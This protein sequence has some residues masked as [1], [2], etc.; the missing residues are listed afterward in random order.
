MPHYEMKT[1]EG[2]NWVEV[3]LNNEM[4]RTES[5]AMRYMLGNIAMESKPSGGGGGGLL[6]GLIKAAVT[7]ESLFRP[8]Y[9]GTGK[10]VLEP[11]LTNFFA[12]QLNNEE[13]ILDR[14]AYWASDASIEV[15]AKRNEAISGLV[16]GEGLFQTSVRGTGT[17]IVQ[18]P[19]PVQTIDL[20]N[21]RLTV[22]GSFAVARTAG[23]NYRV[24]R[25][26]KS[27]LGSMTSGEG[28]VNVIEGT[29][30][31]YLAPVPN[32]YVMLQGMMATLAA[33]AGSRS[34]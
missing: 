26:T 31:V 28:I 10:L 17:V 19:G 21:N 7:G 34:G 29:G 20:Q 16:G 33:S 32:L 11:T 15:T 8:Q 22:D 5:G 2:V 30:R 1:Q 18:A 25:S 9:T 14:G 27:M 4:I 6:G 12:L 24:E 23:L 13:Y 3:T